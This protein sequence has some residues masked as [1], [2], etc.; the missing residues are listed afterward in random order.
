MSVKDKTMTE[1]SVALSDLHMLGYEQGYNDKAIEI[2][3]LH[4]DGNNPLLRQEA[5]ANYLLAQKNKLGYEKREQA[6]IARIT[7]AMFELKDE[8]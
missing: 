6:I 8:N 5:T 1:L 2:N 4:M 3:K 7:K